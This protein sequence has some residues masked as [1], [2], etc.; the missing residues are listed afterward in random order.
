MGAHTNETIFSLT[1][2]PPRLTVV[3]AGPIGVEL[4]QAFARF[5]S[6]VTIVHADSHPLPREDPDAAAIVEQS[7][8][9]DG[10]RILNAVSITKARRDAGVTLLEIEHAGRALEIEAEAVL[11]ATGR[12]PNVEAWAWR[13]QASNTI[14]A[15]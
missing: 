12:T 1:E 6:E 2:L 10:V 15:A 8:E 3:G 13:R 14:E 11:L 7:L 4:A 5:G 9:R